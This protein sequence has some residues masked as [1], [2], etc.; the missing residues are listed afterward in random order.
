MTIKK[1]FFRK[2]FI[3]RNID[4]T[5][6][7]LAMLMGAYFGW[8]ITEIVIFGIFIWI[9]L[10][11]IS[12]RL[13]AIPAL[14]FLAFTPFLLIFKKPELAEESAIYAYYFL[15]MATLMGIYEIRK[16]ENNETHN[17]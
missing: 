16:E 12:S 8:K 17:S 13:I 2:I 4:I 10:N 9:I 11:P 5:I 14:A 15:I 7:V 3:K 6:T 1:E